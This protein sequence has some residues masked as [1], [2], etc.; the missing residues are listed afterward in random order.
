MKMVP[1]AMKRVAARLSVRSPTPRMLKNTATKTQARIQ[2]I[3][4]KIAALTK[5]CFGVT[6]AEAAAHVKA[7]QPL[8]NGK[9]APALPTGPGQNVQGSD[10]TGTDKKAKKP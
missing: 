7:A 8:T 2:N 6:S 5:S 10:I 3:Q 1:T 9:E 4:A